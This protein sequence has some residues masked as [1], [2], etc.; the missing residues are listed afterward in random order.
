MRYLVTGATGFVGGA[1]AELLGKQGHE[2]VALVRDASGARRLERAGLRLHIGDITDLSSV[3]RAADGV[4]GLFHVAGWFKVGARDSAAGWRVNVDGTRNV[5]A[6]AA[7]AATPRVVYT[8]TLAVNGD[9][10]GR[11]VDETYRFTGSHI[12][13][14]DASKAA[15]H[16]LVE[17]TDPGALPVVTV[18]PG[19]VY[20]PGDTGQIGALMARVAAGERVVTT[21]G[22]RMCQAHVED[23]ARGH[24]LAMQRGQ[25]GQSYLLAGPQIA[26]GDLLDLVAEVAG[27]RRPLRVPTPA[28]KAVSALAG[29]LGRL[30]PLPPSYSAETLRVASATYLGSPTKARRDLGWTC[31]PL[32]QGIEQTVAALRGG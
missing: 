2:V 22:P 15:A 5:L 6:A 16:A 32:R 4:D 8:S 14:Y 29:T 10:G 9:T 18:M 17:K 12:T 23:V 25:A 11:T 3:R 31:R 24:L 1:L 7:A 21:T 20:G 27:T 26:L 30:V 28:L 19:G 13:V